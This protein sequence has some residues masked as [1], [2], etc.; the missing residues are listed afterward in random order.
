MGFGVAILN[1]FIEFVSVKWL[2]NLVGNRLSVKLQASLLGSLSNRLY[3]FLL[4][5]RF[6]ATFLCDSM[7]EYE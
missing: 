6:G 5:L 2:K 4:Q 7:N 3:P 1:I